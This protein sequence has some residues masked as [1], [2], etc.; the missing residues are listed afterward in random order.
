MT[1]TDMELTILTPSC[2]FDAQRFTLMRRS[3]R[4]LGIDLPHVVVVEE[5]DLAAFDS[6]RRD[7]GL[8]ILSTKEVLAPYVEWRRRRGKSPNNRAI[9]NRGPLRM[10][11]WFTQQMVKLSADGVIAH[12]HWVCIDSD[13][14][15]LR[16]ICKADFFSPEGLLHLHEFIDLPVGPASQKMSA[17]AAAFLGLQGQ[18]DR[19]YTYVQPIIPIHRNVAA[20]LREHVQITHGLRWELRM[21]AAGATEYTTY[22]M[23]ARHIAKFKELAPVDRRWVHLLYDYD[24]ATL[25]ALLAKDLEEN[26]D[27]R[28]GMVH[29]RLD[30]DTDDYAPILK[31]FWT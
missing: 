10:G 5:E 9:W 26:P 24:R 21:H 25:S 1:S 17:D 29:S 7:P 11:G 18:V 6:H 20:R 3:M 15:F 2:G 19:R 14:F 13:V 8:V 31:R 12:G 22:G 27:R 28:A 30:V 4:E 16:P 23:F